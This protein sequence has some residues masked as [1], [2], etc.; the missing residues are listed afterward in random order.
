[1]RRLGPRMELTLHD[2]IA[3]LRK[4]RWIVIGIVCGCIFAAGFL[5]VQATPVYEGEAK[6]FVGQQQVQVGQLTEGSTVVDLSGKLLKS[7]TEILRTRPIAQAAIDSDEQLSG[8]ADDLAA[9]IRADAILDTQVIRLSYR[10]ADP[11]VAARTVNAVGRAF[12]NQ[13]RDIEVPVGDDDSPAIRVSV[14]EPALPPEAP[15]SPDPVRNLLLAGILGVMLGV[16][17]AFLAETLDTGIKSRED[18]EA[19]SESPVLVTVPLARKGH[20]S[21]PGKHADPAVMES[22]RKLRGAIQYVA[23]DADIR[24]V[25]VTS[26]N[27]GDGKTS[28]ATN[29]A[30]AYAQAKVPTVLIDADLRNPR[31]HEIFRVKHHRGLSHVLSERAGIEEVVLRTRIPT[32]SLITAGAV[33]PNPSELLSSQRLTNLLKEVEKTFEVVVIDSAP[34][35][36]VADTVGISSRVEGTLVVVRGKQTKRSDLLETKSTITGTGGRVLGLALVG[37]SDDGRSPNYY[38]GYGRYVRGPAADAGFEEL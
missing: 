31:L 21:V 36:P 35:L 6:L 7:Y 4:R 14:V 16:G 12:A 25:L 18:A 9:R 23:L 5:T 19:A 30:I 1:M 17:A 13:I 2:Y 26:P 3:V 20:T 37:S 32:L 34:V 15:V 29:L 11:R 10:D 27:A 8:D 38:Y 28:V 24:T 33:P 22:Y